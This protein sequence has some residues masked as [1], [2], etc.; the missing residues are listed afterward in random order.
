VIADLQLP[1]GRLLERPMYAML[2]A[3]LVAACVANVACLFNHL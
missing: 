1:G 2:I 3:T